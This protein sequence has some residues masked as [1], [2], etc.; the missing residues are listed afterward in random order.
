MQMDLFED[1]ALTPDQ[2]LSQLIELRNSYHA[3]RRGLFQRHQDLRNLVTDLQMK[4]EE[5][6]KERSHTPAA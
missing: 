6:S 5:L 4:V 2:V 1:C 3:L